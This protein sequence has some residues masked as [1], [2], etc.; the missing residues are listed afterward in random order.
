[1]NLKTRLAFANSH[2]MGRIRYHAPNLAGETE[3]N[4][5]KIF[6]PIKATARFVRG[7]YCYMESIKSIMKSVGWKLP[8]ETLDQS[9]AKLIHKVM[10]T[11]E[12]CDIYN[13]IK[14][15]R[16]RAC[17][18]VSLKYAPKSDR[19][20]RSTIYSGIKNYNRIPQDLRNLKPKKLKAKLNLKNL[21]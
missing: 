19:L 2:I 4:K 13:L 11:K 10:H 17:A 9:S 21:K 15:P 5:N 20:K 7:S 14:V 16:S 6:R 3:V 8:Q 12:P 1:M 18:D